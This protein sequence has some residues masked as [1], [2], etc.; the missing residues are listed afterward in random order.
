MIA[1]PAVGDDLLR[2][3]EVWRQL[4]GIRRVAGAGDAACDRV[5]RLH[6]TAVALRE[7]GVD[8]RQPLVAEPGGQLLRLDRV[9]AARARLERRRLDLLLS[10]HERPQP[11]LHAA[12]EHGDLLVPEVAQEPPEPRRA[13]VHPLVVGDDEDAGTD[14]GGADGPG[15]ILCGRERVP[16]AGRRGRRGEIA[17]HVEERGSRDVPLEVELT[18]ARRVAELPAAVDEPISQLR[19]R[20]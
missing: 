8:H 17:L 1:G 4:V 16:A 15:E 6:L 2:P 13:S 9:A 14:P 12:A 19:A 18:A 3:E 20:R 10:G 11:R 7:A 5:D